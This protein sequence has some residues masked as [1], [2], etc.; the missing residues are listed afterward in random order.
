MTIKEKE[1][2]LSHQAYGRLRKLPLN[3]AAKK[4]EARIRRI[5]RFRVGRRRE[6]VGAMGFL[7]ERLIREGMMRS[8]LGSHNV[9]DLRDAR[10]KREGN[11]R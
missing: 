6:H 3:T 7:Q 1:A 10:Q 4:R 5:R 9:D 2:E 11:L 8:S